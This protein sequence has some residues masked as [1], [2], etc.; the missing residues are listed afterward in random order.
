M[1]GVLLVITLVPAWCFA[2]KITVGEPLPKVSVSDAGKLVLTGDNIDYAKWS[3]AELTGKVRTVYHLAGSMGASKINEA[4]IEAV[5][6]A[7]LSHEIYQT[8]TVLNLDDALW[9]TTGIVKGKINDKK[10]EFPTSEF[11][12]DADATVRKAWGLEKDSSAVIVL[13]KEGKVL[14]FKDG[15]LS[16]AEIKDFVQTIKDNL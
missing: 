13:D 6:T 8:V 11:V 1:W 2:A 4:Y 16:D 7:D 14:K 5:K 15:K 10:K 9:G 3:S 12:L